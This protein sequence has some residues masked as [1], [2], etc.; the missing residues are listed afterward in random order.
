MK[1]EDYKIFEMLSEKVDEWEIAILNSEYSQ[2][3]LKDGNPEVFSEG[4]TDGLSIR[5]IKDGRQGFAFTTDL[6][7]IKEVVEDAI[8]LSKYK[9]KD[10]FCS[11]YRGGMSISEDHNYYDRSY[12]DLSRNKME[13]LA[14]EAIS[15]AVN[16]GKK[17][18]KVR[19][20]VIAKKLFN[21]HLVNSHGIDIKDKRTDFYLMQEVI[22]ED[23]GDSSTSWEIELSHFLDEIDPRRIGQESARNA[24]GLLGGKRIASGEYPAV[25]RNL[26]S[27]ELLG[28][29]GKSFLSESVHKNRSKLKDRIGERIFS[30][31][32]N[33]IDS[34]VVSQGWNAFPFDGE[35]VPSQENILV[36]DG[37]L[38]GY[39]YDNYYGK[40]YNKKSTGN[41]RRDRYSNPPSQDITNLYIPPGKLT[42]EELIRNLWNGIFITGF[43]GVHTA[44]PVTGD[45]SFG[46]EGFVV[47]NGIPAEPF[48]G[49]AVSGNI[50]ELFNEVIDT[51]SDLRF[52]FSA[53]SPSLLVKKIIIGG[54]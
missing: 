13:E 48:R 38:N 22:A 15:V 20:C 30:K 33:I 3:E 1:V 43:L 46:A 49:V 53:G 51:G 41:C 25:I 14:S 28:I 24:V 26:S 19:K 45:F 16:Y 27:A 6:S 39:L 18:K 23:G 12:I 21:F 40:I 37:V 17:V 32:V 44:N 52:L 35:G 47:S 11:F 34:G 10:E 4:E 7:R 50:F 31:V 29:M 5:I 8:E 36:K 54:V 2:F 42:I 9:D